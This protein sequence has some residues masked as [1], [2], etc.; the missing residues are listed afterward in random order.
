MDVIHARNKT[1]LELGPFGPLREQGHFADQCRRINL[2][3][4]DG[5]FTYTDSIPVFLGEKTTKK[6]CLD[7]LRMFE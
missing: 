4:V 6:E 5:S 1:F 3:I 2:T 7:N